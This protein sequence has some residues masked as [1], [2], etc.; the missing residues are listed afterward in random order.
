VQYLT[1]YFADGLKGFSGGLQKFEKVE[2][3]CRK[4]PVCEKCAAIKNMGNLDVN[5]FQLGL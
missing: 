4:H 3:D 1:E 2:E 5:V